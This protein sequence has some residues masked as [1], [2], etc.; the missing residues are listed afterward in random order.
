MQKMEV[1]EKEASETGII[2]LCTPSTAPAPN[3]SWCLARY[4][5]GLASQEI[6]FLGAGV[7]TTGSLQILGPFQ[8]ILSSQ[9]WE[10]AGLS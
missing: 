9:F 1:R 4:L 6:N 5:W 7:R 3:S 10:G 8:P 2:Y